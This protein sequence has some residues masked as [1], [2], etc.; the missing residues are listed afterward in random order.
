[1]NLDMKW[2]NYVFFD[3]FENMCLL[4]NDLL[5]F[6]ETLK[7]IYLIKISTHEKISKY[8]SYPWKLSSMFKLDNNIILIIGDI[9]VKKEKKYGKYID[10]PGVYKSYISIYRYKNEEFEEILVQNNPFKNDIEKY[11]LGTNY[12]M[13]W[14]LLAVM[15]K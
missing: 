9:E 6:A 11:Y 3:Y 15:I 14:L 12:K 5:C 10:E 4:S 8:L 2:I 7:D 1:M 13:I